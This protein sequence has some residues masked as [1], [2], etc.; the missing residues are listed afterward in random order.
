VLVAQTR[1]RECPLLRHPSTAA[2]VHS[3]FEPARHRFSLLI[4]VTSFPA[5]IVSGLVFGSGWS[6]HRLVAAMLMS[7]ALLPLLYRVALLFVQRD[8]HALMTRLRAHALCPGCLYDLARL[9]VESDGCAVCP[10]CGAA[11]RAA[12]FTRHEPLP[13]GKTG[14]RPSHGRLFRMKVGWEDDDCGLR[15]QIDPGAPGVMAITE[16]DP[17]RRTRL[18]GAAIRIDWRRRR[19][20]AERYWL[21][22]IGAGLAAA[23][24]VLVLAGSAVGY[25]AAGLALFAL[26]P[27][28]A[29]AYARMFALSVAGGPRQTFA[30]EACLAEALCP[31]CLA[32]LPAAALGEPL[33]CPA[34]ASS[35]RPAGRPCRGTS[36][37]AARVA[38]TTCEA[39]RPTPRV[40]C[41][42]LS[43]EPDGP[44]SRS[45]GRYTEVWPSHRTR[46]GM[47]AASCG[48]S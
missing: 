18:E 45:S 24:A 9:P 2:V 31:R 34:C 33:R 22:G 5:M 6:W 38:A 28:G 17:S 25:F 47:T 37:A 46:S 12:A 14:P 41:T 29:V 27:V 44:G 39:C 7:L 8:A 3:A 30:V 48:R 26:L 19:R 35:W 13:Q 40:L 32:D 11:W 36:P 4:G 16:S 20:R 23:I 1:V 15:V 43:A 42:A 10:E 21:W